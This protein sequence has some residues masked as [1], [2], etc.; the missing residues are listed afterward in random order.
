MLVVPA[1]TVQRHPVAKLT[2]SP[3]VL[4]V[5]GAVIVTAAAPF[6]VTAP[7]EV[8]FPFKVSSPAFVNVT[9][10]RWWS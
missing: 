5:R 1:P 9:V 10:P 4:I 8:M 7:S 2:A 6:C 3:V